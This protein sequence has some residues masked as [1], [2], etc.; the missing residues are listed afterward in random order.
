[1]LKL[2]AVVSG[3][4]YVMYQHILNVIDTMNNMPYPY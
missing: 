1:M 3:L 4:V 2:I